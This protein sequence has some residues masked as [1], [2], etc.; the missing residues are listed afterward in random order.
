VTPPIARILDAR[1]ATRV[2]L[3]PDG[4]HVAYVTDLT[5]TPQLWRVPASGG[6]PER[7]TFD[8]DRV[9]AYRFSPDGRRIAYGAD[10]GG[11]ERWQIWAMNADGTAARRLTDTDDRIHHLRAWTQDGRS[12]LVHA[13][14][15]DPRF[16]DLLAYDA[17]TGAP[18]VLFRHDGTASNATA[19]DD[20]S[21]VVT[22]N[23]A[24]SDEN[25]LILVTPDGAARQL[26]PDD[27]P[28]LYSIAGA[29]PGGF[30]VRSDRG[31]DFVGLATFSLRDGALRFLR[32]PDRDV[33]DADVS[34]RLDAYVVNSDGHSEVRIAD[35]DRDDIVQ[36]LPPGSLAQDLIGD[37]LALHDGTA[38]VAWAR[39]DSPSSIFIA[40][41]GEPAREVVPPV[42]AG[43]DPT[44]LP[45]SR[46]VDWPTFDGK[47]IPGF[48][49][50]P[51]GAPAGPRPT[52]IDVHGGPEGQARPNWNPRS[53]ALVAN[54]FNVLWPNV[55]G[56]SGYGKSYRALD[57]VRLRMD[58]VRDLDAAAAWLGDAGI[59]PRDRIGVMGQSY[60]GYMTL[61]ALAFFPERR[62]AAAVDLYG[63]ANFVSF[64]EHTDP[65]RRPLRAVE[66]GDPVKDH[67]FLVSISP[68][69]KLDAIRAPLMVI[70]GAND[71]RVPIL[72]TEQI[73]TALRAKG[74]EVEYVRL[75][76]E[77]HGLAKA[78]NRADVYPK[79]LAFFQRHMGAA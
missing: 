4:A 64:F 14:L 6:A 30:V 12:L 79:V 27:P 70:H 57:D 69:T 71:P 18:R 45:E 65:W 17:E 20:G 74:R 25:H 39:Y 35:G 72:E 62:W 53:V 31:R 60:G 19:L 59:A 51:R 3:S 52:V 67:D 16:F 11:N 38:A 49:L 8:C 41:R 2:R 22:V 54:G 77:G 33:E 43:L 15:R 9:G 73:V 32:T 58:S 1:G 10:A 29:V 44:D 13:N 37:G 68:L 75:E 61:A 28:A 34:G 7:L 23:R 40:R 63:I 42:L 36:G 55:R 48:L 56:S 46:L 47:R 66:Y 78:K 5:G 76:D 26:T 50:T 24:R 21:V